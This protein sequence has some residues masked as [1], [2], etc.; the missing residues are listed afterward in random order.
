[1]V[2]TF[3]D[4]CRNNCNM[5][6]IPYYVSLNSVGLS[7]R[8]KIPELLSIS[9]QLPVIRSED[10]SRSQWVHRGSSLNTRTLFVWCLYIGTYDYIRMD[11]ASSCTHHFTYSFVYFTHTQFRHIHY[12]CIYF[13]PTAIHTKF[14]S[15]VLP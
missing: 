10:Y 6:R 11:E 3:F 1:M 5:G 9:R 12:T 2:S 14:D 15:I 4:S 13:N 8:G 7:T